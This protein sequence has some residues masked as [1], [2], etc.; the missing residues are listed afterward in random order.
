[1]ADITNKE[2]LVV[3]APVDDH[4]VVPNAEPIVRCT[5]QPFQVVLGKVGNLVEFVHDPISHV[6][7]G[8]TQSLGR[9]V[10]HDNLGHGD[11]ADSTLS[12][13]VPVLK[14]QRSE[15]SE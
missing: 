3:F 14:E 13:G 15:R 5:T 11:Y 1:M 8:V 9:V 7:F 2:F 6:R 10:R 4:A 12:S